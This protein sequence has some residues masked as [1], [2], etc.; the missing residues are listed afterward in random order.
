MIKI[1]KT[2][3]T[4]IV[5]IA[6]V[7]VLIV[8]GMK[9]LQKAKEKDANTPKAKIYPIVVTTLSP[10]LAQVEL[11]LP[12]LADVANDKDVKLSSRIS[13]RIVAIKPSGSRV[14]KGEVVVKLDTTSIKSALISLKEQ[15]QATRVSFRNLKATHK[16]TLELLKIQGASVEESQKEM[17]M[18]ANS[19]A[20][21]ASLKQ[22]E[23]ELKNNL[24]YAT[25]TSPVN[26]VIAKTFSNRGA[27]SAPGKP[28]VAISSKNGFYLM[29]RVPSK[30]TMRGV[31]FHSK[32]FNVTPLGSTF[33]GLSEYKVYTGNTQF[34]SGDRVEVDVIVFKAKATLLPFDALLDRDGLTYI[35]VVNG[36]KATPQKV[37]IIQS[38]EQG[39][40]VS[41]NLE[42]KEIVIAKPDI[43]LRLASGYALKVKE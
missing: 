2:I 37:N 12:Y 27:L 10:K 41:E 28:L 9:A 29:V 19:Q 18:M 24:S 22:Q 38:A 6:V 1:L 30:V 3:L 8:G 14:K 15:L 40:V 23:I 32:E 35:L 5:L 34:T 36:D 25:I 33:Q 17:G 31:K 20:K 11:T 7:L 26:G 4:F 42:D 16:R 43:L 13:A 21:L 39:V